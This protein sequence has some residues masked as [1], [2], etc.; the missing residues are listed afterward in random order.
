MAF[1]LVDTRE[2]WTQV[3]P[4]RMPDTHI[5]GYLDRHGIPW[6]VQKLDV[7]DYML[8]CGSVTVDRKKDLEEVASNL[9]NPADRARFWNEVRLAYRL[10]IKLVVLV[11][12]STHQGKEDVRGW[13]SSY[14]PANGAALLR[15]M[16][17]LKH[18]YGVLFYVCHKRSTGRRIVQL[19]SGK[20]DG[21]W[22]TII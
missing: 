2:Q 6:K 9:L 14:S 15:Q 1:L 21:K 19:L 11:E 3:R 16:E 10:G 22:K 17:A 5:S 8:E 13:R 20:D 18:S 7:G 12:D 4:G